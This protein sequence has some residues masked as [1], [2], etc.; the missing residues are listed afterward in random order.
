[1][2]SESMATDDPGKS[3]ARVGDWLEA[4]SIHGGVARRGEVVEVLGSTGHEHYRV[5]WEEA[6]ES[7]VFPA[8]GV[9]VVPRGQARRAGSDR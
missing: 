3:R 8:D 7:I 5:R 9:I 4:H 1:M 6:H 2:P